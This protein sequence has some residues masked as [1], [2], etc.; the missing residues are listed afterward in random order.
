[1]EFVVNNCFNKISIVFFII[2]ILFLSGCFYIKEESNAPE[3]V[4]WQGLGPDKWASIWLIKRYISPKSKITILPVGTPVQL[5]HSFDIPDGQYRRKPGITTFSALRNKFSIEGRIIVKIEGVL[6]DIEIDFW[7]KNKFG[8]SAFIEQG[9]RLLQER[10][11]RDQVPFNCYIAFFDNVELTLRKHQIDNPTLLLPNDSCA[12]GV[13]AKPQL[14]NQILI[15]DL[16]Q[17]M[18]K[19]KRV[20][21][22]DARESFEFSEGRIPGAYN[23][24][25]RHVNT[26]TVKPFL[27]SELVIAYC[28]KDFR[29]FE[30][31]KALQDNGVKNVAILDPFGLKGWVNSGL[32][33]VGKKGLSELQANNELEMCINNDSRCKAHL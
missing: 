15:K 5:D 14:V 8:E 21:F 9:F 19:K 11:G 10:F 33:I 18:Q 26:K 22:V 24:Q 28:V 2:L 32:P 29:G 13:K 6:Q 12:S 3:F 31:A 30:L 7:K 4:T 17:E 16:M 25:I 1:M 27:D 23:L 20:K